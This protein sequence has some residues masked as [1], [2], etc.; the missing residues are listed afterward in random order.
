MKSIILRFAIFGA[1]INAQAAPAAEAAEETK[2]DAVAVRV[3]PGV[4]CS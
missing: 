4:I 3:R 2:A 1:T